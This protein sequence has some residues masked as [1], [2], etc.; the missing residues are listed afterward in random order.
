MREKG[1]EVVFSGTV[2]ECLDQHCSPLE[3]EW[4]LNQHWSP[5]RHLLWY[6]QYLCFAFDLVIVLM[7]INRTSNCSS[8]EISVSAEEISCDNSLVAGIDSAKAN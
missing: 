7:I 5:K 3:A 2:V 8:S 1:G 6:G 4:C